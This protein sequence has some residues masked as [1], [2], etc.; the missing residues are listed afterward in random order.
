M[1]RKI[2]I[3]G[4]LVA[5]ALACVAYGYFI[6]PRRLVVNEYEIPVRGWNRAFEGFRI[7]TISD[8]HSGS[9]GGDAA[10]IRRVVQT[11]NEQHADIVVLLGDFVSEDSRFPDGLKMPLV[12]LERN[13]A[14]LR[15]KYGVFAVLGN[16]D[17]AHN[18]ELVVR[19]L[20]V[21]GYAVLNGAV[22][23]IEKDGQKLRIAGLRDHLNIGDWRWYADE[24]RRILAPTEGAGDVIVLQHS[25]DIGPIITGEHSISNDLKLM[26]SGH[27]HGGQVWLPVVG[28][29]I[30]PS[31]YGQK[32]AAGFS[33]DPVLPVFVTTG[34]GTSILPFRFMV[35]PEIAVLT[36]RRAEP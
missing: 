28:R 13:I 29:P 16:H 33:D 5:V 35:P 30:V 2:Y 9:N 25:P 17:D 1:K 36:I 23:V 3:A 10:Q 18:G 24:N 11:A 19:A 12:E 27:T 15:A 32:F 22:A 34:I 6:E 7:V 4:A 14:G 8:I 20:S 21:N 26:L 31:W